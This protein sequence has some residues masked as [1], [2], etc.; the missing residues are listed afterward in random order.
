MQKL[1]CQD[2]SD[3]A[4]IN[5]P[6]ISIVVPN[7]NGGKTIEK[8]LKSLIDQE[9]SNLELIVVDGGSTDNSVEIIEKYSQ[10]ITWWISEKDNGQ[11]SAINKGFSKC[12][13]DIVNWLCSDDLLAPGALSIVAREFAT[14]PEIDVLVGR[15]EMRIL[16]E[17]VK[18][19]LKGINFWTKAFN[20]TLKTGSRYIIVDD[21][22]TS[23]FIKAPTM[24]HIKLMPVHNP[25]PQPSCFYR[26]QLLDREPIIDESYEYAMDFEL[27]NYFSAKQAHWKVVDDILSINPVSGDNKTSVGG[28]DATYEVEKIYRMYTN[29]WIPLTFWHRRFRYPLE[30][31]VKK[32]QGGIW[33]FVLGPVWVLITLVLSIFYGLKHVWAM[34]WTR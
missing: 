3:Q 17:S 30:Q 1:K 32:K 8:T 9:Y 2:K 29:E 34:R 7:Y 28:V 14:H 24:E 16:S 23:G 10:F 21:S 19:P 5:R 15:C 13:G 18:Q 20:K 12:T 25:I 4:N 11:S 6:K 33:L 31:F 27:W 22:D 26:R